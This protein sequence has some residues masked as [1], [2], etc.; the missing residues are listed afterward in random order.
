MKLKCP[1]CGK[2]CKPHAFKTYHRYN[3]SDTTWSERIGDFKCIKYPDSHPKR[4][5]PSC[6]V[7]LKDKTILYYYIGEWNI[8]PSQTKHKFKIKKR[9]KVLKIEQGHFWDYPIK[10]NF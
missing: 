7:V 2:E 9:K 10:A 3:V 5:G 8:L 4:G 1:V 6:F